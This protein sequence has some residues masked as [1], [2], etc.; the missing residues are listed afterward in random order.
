MTVE[1]NERGRSLANVRDECELAR[2]RGRGLT[3]VAAARK[4]SRRTLAAARGKAR[5][6]VILKNREIA[7][8]DVA[9]AEDI[10]NI[11][12]SKALNRGFF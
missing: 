11:L 6:G 7:V 5:G 1:M 4:K 8:S 9:R 10:D 12:P 3:R 2:K